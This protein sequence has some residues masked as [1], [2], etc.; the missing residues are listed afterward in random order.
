FL[1]LIAGTGYFSAHTLVTVNHQYTEAIQEM[2]AVKNLQLSVLQALMPPNDALI[3]PASREDIL[4]E[5]LA[6]NV[7]RAFAATEN[8]FEERDEQ[9]LL[10]SALSGWQ[11]VKSIGYEIIHSRADTPGIS[12]RMEEMDARAGQVTAD[13]EELRNLVVSELDD[14][15]KESEAARQLTNR[16][17]GAATVLA[18]LGGSIF[19]W[20]FPRSIVAPIQQLRDAAE[21]VGA[22]QWDL[23]IPTD[24]G[25]ELGDLGRAFNRMAVQ[26]LEA[27]SDLEKKILAR[28]RALSTVNAVAEAASR[29]LD[30]EAI[31]E[32]ALDKVL[33]GMELAAAE[34]FL[35][36][37]TKAELSLAAHRGTLDTPLC[38]TS[39]FAVGEGLPGSV[40]KRGEAISTTNLTDETLS[41]RQAVIEMGIGSIACVPLRAKGEIVGALNVAA[42]GDRPFSEEEIAL[43]ESISHQLGLAVEN[44]RLFQAEHTQRELADNLRRAA[45]EMSS[46]L[47]PEAVYRAVLS[48]ASQVLNCDLA[49]LLTLNADELEIA[50]IYGEAATQSLRN[51]RFPL[52]ASPALRE[53]VVTREAHTFCEPGRKTPFNPQT[54]RF[55]DI[56]W[57]LVVPLLRGE[58]V[59]G[60]LALE[61]QGHCY[62]TEYEIKIAWTFANHAAVAIENAR[63]YSQIKAFNQ[64]LEARVAERTEELAEARDQ[65][66]RQ[67]AQLRLLLKKTVR[68]QE[69]ER[70]R[71]A[72]EI[73]DGLTQWVMGAL[74]ELQAAKINLPARPEE[75]LK[76]L[77]NAQEILKQI[78]TEMRRTIFDLRPP[79]LETRGLIAAVEE[80]ATVWQ[81]VSNLTCKVV[82]KG[83]PVPLP[84]EESINIYRIVQEALNN[85]E[86]HANAHKAEI[87]FHFKKEL[88]E[89]R[90]ADDGRG[91]EA[92]PENFPTASPNH[93]GLYGMHERAASMGG[94]LQITSLPGNG[95]RL[96]LKIP[97]APA[98]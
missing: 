68:V 93:L 90:L 65:L 33:Q 1:L 70:K 22:G 67:A 42:Y 72:Q 77:T 23:P 25:D 11:E 8:T 37:E 12:E 83:E 6:E 17:L 5:N 24:R 48:R 73:H 63:L 18:I 78:K 54:D 16:L 28:T 13:L 30:L 84:P 32:Q 53:V 50:S 49:C 10:A 62:E 15:L 9:Q 57:C 79:L 60:L 61:Q 45:R 44:A 4:F 87:S 21:A 41:L 69:D 75:A 34:I 14:A 55:E 88:L 38:E 89:I 86:K 35:L 80:L 36:D 52:Q 2:A 71:I 94:R 85:I 20:T 26:L 40:A 3:R 59:L 74:F 56:E 98:P 96:V 7:D 31:I 64:E 19:A 47:E 58:D 92:I 66:S 95:T 43:L 46:L 97:L 29:S 82:V 27:R 39:R 91:M 76:K 81:Q 51:Y